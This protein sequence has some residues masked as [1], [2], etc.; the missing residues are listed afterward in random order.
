VICHEE[1]E[2]DRRDK[3]LAPAGDAAKVQGAALERAEA[4]AAWE[5]SPWGRAATAYAR[6]VDRQRPTKWASPALRSSAPS[7]ANP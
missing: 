4:A 7:A 1:M 6:A 2:P 3:V 5:D